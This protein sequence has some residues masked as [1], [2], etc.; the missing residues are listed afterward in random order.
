MMVK[1]VDC[2]EQGGAHVTAGTGVGLRRWDMF[3]RR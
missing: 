3:I 2:V 1:T